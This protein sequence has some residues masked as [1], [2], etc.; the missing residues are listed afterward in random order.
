MSLPPSLCSPTPPT[1]PSPLSLSLSSRPLSL[2]LLTSQGGA[3]VADNIASLVLAPQ[4][5]PFHLLSLYSQ[6]LSPLLSP[7]Y[8][9]QIVD[10]TALCVAANKALHAFLSEK[11]N[12]KSIHSEIIFNLS[13]NKNVC[14]QSVT[15]VFLLFS[16][17]LFI[18][19]L[20][21]R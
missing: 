7:H 10:E 21:C 17:I 6:F 9:Y 16:L 4:T 20:F 15:F 19:I 14:P 8:L 12:T 2:S 18:L 13:P 3:G 11:L 5:I 1:L